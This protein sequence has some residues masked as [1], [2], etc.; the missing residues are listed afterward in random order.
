MSFAY[1]PTTS[2]TCGRII[3][4]RFLIYASL[5]EKGTSHA[6]AMTHL[7]LNRICCRTTIISASPYILRNGNTGTTS[8]KYSKQEESKRSEKTLSLSVRHTKVKSVQDFTRPEPKQD[9][10]RSFLRHGVVAVIGFERDEHGDIVMVDVGDQQGK[11]M[12]PRLQLC[13]GIAQNNV[14][15]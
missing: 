9:I 10:D 3:A 6:D 13:H 7:G 12:V 11:Y 1:L 2:C 15:W 4:D 14:S 8:I 5:V